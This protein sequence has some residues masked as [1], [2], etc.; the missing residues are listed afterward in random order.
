MRWHQKGP[1]DCKG[2]RMGCVITDQLTPNYLLQGN[3]SIPF[4]LYSLLAFPFV[5]E[6]R[7]KL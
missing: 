7:W 6:A 2:K 4:L 3:V 1:E 5:K